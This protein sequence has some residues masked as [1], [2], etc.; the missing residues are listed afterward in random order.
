[1]QK[2]LAR[3]PRAEERHEKRCE[4]GETVT[5]LCHEGEIQESRI[6]HP[7]NSA[8]ARALA[9]NCRHRVVKRIMHLARLGRG[10]LAISVTNLRRSLAGSHS[11]VRTMESRYH[12]RN[13]V[14]VWGMRGA[15]ERV[16]QIATSGKNIIS[17]LRKFAN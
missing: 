14:L 12:D 7:I 3:L 11:S 5:N 2:D 17:G 6:L 9:K 4:I 13:C 16:F 8:Y 10:T 15:V 1:M